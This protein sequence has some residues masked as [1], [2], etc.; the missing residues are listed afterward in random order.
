MKERPSRD[1]VLMQTAGLWGMR[2]TC[3]RAQVGVVISRDGRILSSGYNGSP[4]GMP[5]CNH[6]CDCV[7]VQAKGGGINHLKGCAAIQPCRNVVH[8]EANAIAFAARYG[9]GVMGAEL[10]TTRVPCL[11]CAGMIINAGI[12]RVVWNE[13]HRE[14]DGF[15]RLGEA[16]I[17]VIRYEHG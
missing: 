5:H 2:S 10:H 1:W 12:T 6:S 3:T 13:E 9:V 8:A 17:E 4:S 7:P 15:L 11:N 16:G 14:M